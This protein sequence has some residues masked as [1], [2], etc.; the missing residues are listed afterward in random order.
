MVS[1][2]VLRYQRNRVNIEPSEDVWAF[3]QMGC[4]VDIVVTIHE[5]HQRNRNR[6]PP[7]R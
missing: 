5:G 6:V 4:I 2:G 7:A 3:A 1:V